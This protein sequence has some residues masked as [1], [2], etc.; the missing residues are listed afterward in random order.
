MTNLQGR[1]S[2]P[3]VEYEEEEEE[4]EEGDIQLGSSG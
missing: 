4:E 2:Y 1:C 3:R